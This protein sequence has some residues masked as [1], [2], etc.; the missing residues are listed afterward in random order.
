MTWQNGWWTGFFQQRGD[1]DVH[2]HHLCASPVE[3]PKLEEENDGS[4]EVF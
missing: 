2:G 1:E 3:K 4:R